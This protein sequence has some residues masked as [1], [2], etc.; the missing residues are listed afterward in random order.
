MFC[1]FIDH[2]QL[3]L[4]IFIDLTSIEARIHLYTPQK[5]HLDRH[6]GTLDNIPSNKV[7]SLIGRSYSTGAGPLMARSITSPT[8]DSYAY[9]PNNSFGSTP[10]N[11]IASFQTLNND[12]LNFKPTSRTSNLNGINWNEDTLQSRVI[13]PS[14]NNLSNNNSMNSLLNYRANMGTSTTAAL[15]TSLSSSNSYVN[16]NNNNSTNTGVLSRLVS[17]VTHYTQHNNTLQTLSRQNSVVTV[18]GSGDSGG[19][20]ITLGGGN[21][22]PSV[23][24][25]AGLGARNILKSRFEANELNKINSSNDKSS[26]PVPHNNTINNVN[27]SINNLSISNVNT[28]VNNNNNSANTSIGAPSFALNPAL[29]SLSAIASHLG[30]QSNLSMNTNNTLTSA[31]SSNSMS[32]TIPN[33]A[34]TT[35]LSSQVAL[36]SVP[37][38]FSTI[39]PI[40]TTHLQRDSI[41]SEGTEDESSSSADKKT[42][43]DSTPV[44]SSPVSPSPA[45]VSSPSNSPHR[46][47]RSPVLVELLRLTGDSLAFTAFCQRIESSMNSRQLLATDSKLEIDKKKKQVE[48]KKNDTAKQMKAMSDMMKS[49]GVTCAN[50]SILT[51]AFMSEYSKRLSNNTN[52][53]KMA[54]PPPTS[55]SGL[56]AR[57]TS[58]SSAPVIEFNPFK[59]QLAPRS[60]LERGVS[61]SGV[62]SIREP[63]GK[64]TLKVTD[65]AATGSANL[66]VS[67]SFSSSSFTQFQ[68]SPDSKLANTLNHTAIVTDQST[69][70]SLQSETDTDDI[71]FH[72]RHAVIPHAHNPSC[73]TPESSKSTSSSLRSSSVLRVNPPPPASASA[74]SIQARN[75]DFLVG[76]PSVTPYA[77]LNVNSLH[78]SSSSTVTG[79][80]PGVP[81]LAA[82]NNFNLTALSNSAS[83]A[84]PPSSSNLSRLVSGSQLTS[85]VRQ[86]RPAVLPTPPCSQP[87]APSNGSTPSC[88]AFLLAKPQ[89]SGNVLSGFSK[90]FNPTAL[91]LFSTPSLPPVSIPPTLGTN[92][93]SSNDAQQSGVAPAIPSFSS[94]F[95]L[96]NYLPLPVNSDAKTA[97]TSNKLT[98]KTC[99][100]CTNACECKN[101]MNSE[102]KLTQDN[103]SADSADL[104]PAAHSILQRDISATSDSSFLSIA[105]SESLL[106]PPDIQLAPLAP[107]PTEVVADAPQKPLCRI[108]CISTIS[109]LLMPFKNP[110]SIAQTVGDAL[111]SAMRCTP[112]TLKDNLQIEQKT[113]AVTTSNISLI[114]EP[115]EL[116]PSERRHSLP[117]VAAAGLIP[118]SHVSVSHAGESPSSGAGVPAVSPALSPVLLPS[119]SPHVE[120]MPSLMPE[121]TISPS[122]N[123]V[124]LSSLSG[125]ALA[126]FFIRSGGCFRAPV[127]AKQ[128][129]VPLC[130]MSSAPSI[131]HHPSHTPGSSFT[132]F[133]PS[134]LHTSFKLN[135]SADNSSSRLFP[136]KGASSPG[137]ESPS[138]ALPP[139]L[140]LVKNY[141]SSPCPDN[142]PPHSV[143]A[144]AAAEM[145]QLSR[146]VLSDNKSVKGCLPPVLTSVTPVL[147]Y[148]LLRGIAPDGSRVMFDVSTHTLTALTS[149][150]KTDAASIG[151]CGGF[152]VLLWVLEIWTVGKIVSNLNLKVS[153]ML[154]QG[155]VSSNNVG[156]MASSTK[157]DEMVVMTGSFENNKTCKMA[158]ATSSSCSGWF[159]SELIDALS[160]CVRLGGLHKSQYKR[161]RSRIS[162]LLRGE[163]EPRLVA[164][165]LSFK[166]DIAL[167]GHSSAYEALAL[168][169]S[170]GRC[171]MK[172][173]T[174]LGSWMDDWGEDD[175]SD[176]D[177]DNNVS[178][179]EKNNTFWCKQVSNKKRVTSQL[180]NSC[181]KN[182][183]TDLSSSD[184]CSSSES[185][186]EQC[187]RKLS[188][189]PHPTAAVGP[190]M[191]K[192]HECL[193]KCTN[194]GKDGS[195]MVTSLGFT[196]G[197]LDMTQPSNNN[198]TNINANTSTAV[199]A[200]SSSSVIN[201]ST[202]QSLSGNSRGRQMMTVSAC[203]N[204]AG[205]P[206]VK[207][208]LIQNF[209]SSTRNKNHVNEN[210]SSVSGEELLLPCWD[211]LHD[212]LRRL[213]GYRGILDSFV[214]VDPVSFSSSSSRNILN[215]SSGEN[216]NKIIADDTNAIEEYGSLLNEDSNLEGE[217]LNNSSED[218]V[219]ADDNSSVYDTMTLKK[220][221]SLSDM[222]A[223]LGLEFDSNDLV[224]SPSISAEE[225]RLIDLEELYLFKPHV[226]K[227]KQNSNRDIASNPL[228]RTNSSNNLS[229]SAS[230]TPIPIQRVNSASTPTSVYN[231]PQKR[232]QPPP[233]TTFFGSPSIAESPAPLPSAFSVSSSIIASTIVPGVS[234]STPLL[235]QNVS[236]S[237]L[238][239]QKLS[240][241]VHP[242]KI[243]PTSTCWFSPVSHCR[244]VAAF[245]DAT[246]SV[247]PL[248][249]L[250]TIQSSPTII[251]SESRNCDLSRNESLSADPMHNCCVNV[252]HVV[253]TSPTG[254][255]RSNLK[256]DHVIQKETST[257][258]L[259][260]FL[261][262]VTNK[263]DDTSLPEVILL[264]RP[265]NL[266]PCR[267]NNFNGSED[268]RSSLTGVYKPHGTFFNSSPSI[269]NFSTTA[270]GDHFA[271]MANGSTSANHH[272]S[273]SHFRTPSAAPPLCS[274]SPVSVIGMGGGKHS[275]SSP[276]TPTTTVASVFCGGLTNLVIDDI[277]SN[278]QQDAFLH[279][280]HYVSASARGASPP[281]ERDMH[282][283]GLLGGESRSEHDEAMDELV[284]IT[285]EFD[286]ISPVGNKSLEM[287]NN[288]NQRD[289][290][291]SNAAC[292]IMSNL[293]CAL[294]GSF[295]IIETSDTKISEGQNSIQNGVVSSGTNST[296]VVTSS[297]AYPSLNALSSGIL[298]MKTK[299]S[300][301]QKRIENFRLNSSHNLQPTLG[302]S[303]IDL[304]V[305]SVQSAAPPLIKAMFDTKAFKTLKSVLEILETSNC[306]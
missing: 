199:D 242:P 11:T 35:T 18:G 253:P 276:V 98:D 60:P 142:Y 248:G 212:S 154:P 202:L 1:L 180:K 121:A 25:G 178:M 24:L 27:N 278:S 172:M 129:Q 86:C 236:S 22:L 4:K 273:S 196:V 88:P 134:Y 127:P 291:L 277:W 132:P 62:N 9:I 296:G 176:D 85:M 140:L 285:E 215:A 265:R 272:P 175:S 108:A 305:C 203:T 262:E 292:V 223:M 21:L 69:A 218:E 96:N 44:S 249:S 37:T 167:T 144:E 54:P 106:P 58:L 267:A 145:S 34:T 306:L 112:P 8:A 229:S 109:K 206:K 186:Y 59:S 146:M 95:S 159:I 260:D 184:A 51:D 116:S 103:I 234:L 147:L 230:T 118:A 76:F 31:S 286:T 28:Y 92:A 16:I 163:L 79:Q 270:G 3:E 111:S 250:T 65:H 284:M 303:K 150:V 289:R 2:I 252:S 238:V 30:V 89:M 168:C 232:I 83:D 297:A 152:D 246:N 195:K 14:S 216:E 275:V 219:N 141:L 40:T 70:P 166:K 282:D 138:A 153:D 74:T 39:P 136:S 162:R 23:S 197:L 81:S 210:T 101:S 279:D 204:G 170:T 193:S 228:I 72:R 160:L 185:D 36:N 189:L 241:P 287:K 13:R 201:L 183:A 207:D 181:S 77:P 73:N 200:S 87:A 42:L 53:S 133:R 63:D 251:A 302:I 126:T 50:D 130:M 143:L 243:A 56:L 115:S 151:L 99:S 122:C 263:K 231:N 158:G 217:K 137:I 29:K 274:S 220:T 280:V 283:D 235:A 100:L 75:S 135:C 55:T 33:E 281:A 269:D 290:H 157:V 239:N 171:E 97:I 245:N 84:A 7:G 102:I 139:N 120:S 300:Q 128:K 192:V 78:P 233:L 71:T 105:P 26:V 93:R 148:L 104:S 32:S 191:Q 156:G 213:P 49:Y 187:A 301:R 261:L 123:D 149:F 240:S 67:S 209:S 68:N 188:Q 114:S 113:Q 304:T 43:S 117:N 179:T 19:G 82:N 254:S 38:S 295:G 257:P 6:F 205:I 165:V 15:L 5:E 299:K 12:N 110:C 294:R 161:V 288:L 41:V 222:N 155:L 227:G 258:Q 266:T 64:E 194:K 90:M 45:N 46:S 48:S 264:P 91:N 268:L 214:G 224:H 66:A 174:E 225:A 247:N 271:T 125:N 255:M 244:E 211:D 61:I 119:A 131:A 256:I 169:L 164:R 17:D 124:D 298:S 107:T 221:C 80:M 226:F 177:E 173:K 94:P 20:G 259:T 47:Q 293:S 52:S 190:V 10:F 182:N 208:N 198:N 237:S 57:E